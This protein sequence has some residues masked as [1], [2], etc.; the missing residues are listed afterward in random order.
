MKA[1]AIAPAN[2]AFIKY[3]GK[4]DT[5]LRLPVNSSVSMNLGSCTTTTTVEFR[6]ELKKDEISCLKED[7]SFKEKQR[8][9]THLD[10]IRCKAGLMCFASVLTT[11]NFPGSSGV[12]SSASGF[13][14]LSVAAVSALNLK[15]SEKELTVLARLGS[16]SACRSIPDGFV[17]WV[18]GD[19]SG[20]SYAY[21]LYPPGYWDLCD[22][23][24]IVDSR[25][26]KVSTTKGMETVR[27]S[28]LLN[29]RLL[30]IPDRMKRLKDAMAKKDLRSLGEV[31]EE[32]CLDMHAVMQS[33]TPP[34]YYRNET[35]KRIMEAVVG[36]R[37]EGIPVYFTIDAGPNVH[38][39]FEG[40]DK[41]RI[42]HALNKIKGVE[43]IILNIPA[44]G[45]RLI[46][47]DLF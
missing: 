23:L 42:L 22:L 8:I 28:P 32:D 29:K 19:G 33:Q 6:Q 4:A 1:T 34:L 2:I 12:A 16:G 37:N 27:T 31:I 15:L 11:N 39:I 43:N 10:L 26:K 21:S 3:W 17:E 18:K 35:T 24:V 36:W 46:N 47:E 14:A 5:K 20:S 45:A 7:F 38:L 44:S 9:R 30:A 13:A 41:D 40:K 25:T